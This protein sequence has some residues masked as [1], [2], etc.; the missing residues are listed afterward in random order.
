MSDE[1]KTNPH[2][3]HRERMRA[4][5]EKEGADHFDSHQ[6]LEMYLF[7]A[8]PRR[9]TNEIAHRLLE[10]FGSLE[11]VF[12]A[13]FDDLIQVE[14]I[15]R[16]TATNI[17]LTAAIMRRMAIESYHPPKKYDHFE[18]IVRYLKSIYTGITVERVYLLLFDNGMKMLDCVL[19]DEG[20]V[21]QANINARKI[22]E[23]AIKKNASSVMLA[24]NHPG[25]VAIPSSEDIATTHFLYNTLQSIG[26]TLIDHVIVGKQTVMPILNR[27]Q[28]NLRPSPITGKIDEDFYR[29]FY[30][31]FDERNKR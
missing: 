8:L 17:K 9:D 14:G 10:R 21:N 25:G 29:A 2:A 5:F 1:T 20:T 3:G 26:L 15:S 31:R 12:L 16:K 30:G 13:E 27:Q 11:E 18:D 22:M 28:G 23:H 4:R 24:H 6:L 19:L 7:P